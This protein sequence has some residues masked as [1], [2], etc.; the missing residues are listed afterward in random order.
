MIFAEML[1]EMQ[2][3]DEMSITGCNQSEPSD[4]T[5]GKII[6]DTKLE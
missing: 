6:D 3:D 1:S 4:N 2:A 5:T